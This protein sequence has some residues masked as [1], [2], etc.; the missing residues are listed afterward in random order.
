MRSKE[1]S[2][3]NPFLVIFIL[4]IIP[5][6][7]SFAQESGSQLTKS[8]LK[9]TVQ[10]KLVKANLLKNDN[11]NVEVNDNSIILSGT[12]PT[13]Y[14]K[15]KAEQVAQSVDE[16]YAVINKLLV[17]NK[18]VGDSTLTKE[19]L[20]KI[21]SNIFYGVF[22]WLTVNADNGIVTLGGWVHLPW[23]KHQFES[24]VEKVPGV[25][26]VVNKIQKTFGP[27]ELGYRA[28]RLIYNDPMFWGQQY[29]SNPPIHI[30]V[31][32]GSIFLFGTVNAS[33]EKSWAENVIRFQTDAISVENDL[34]V[35]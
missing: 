7:L 26:S 17:E 35:E 8:N 28:A 9:I 1:K 13:L 24:E 21:H 6:S 31:D 23:L 30:I 27:G 29:S 11:I 20:N 19:I 4:I 22:D 33:V 12:V 2:I 16:N 5:A 10:Y 18:A 34:K 25:M 32:N 3:I 14:D 15:E